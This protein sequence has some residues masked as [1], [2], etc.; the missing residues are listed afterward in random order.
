M[1]REETP[2]RGKQ[3]DLRHPAAHT[4][5]PEQGRGGGAA[6]G[7][8]GGGAAGGRIRQEGRGRL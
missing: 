2:R 4:E 6:A 8:E 1:P 3:A 5:H 7:R